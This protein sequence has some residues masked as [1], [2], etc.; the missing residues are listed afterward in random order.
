ME[1]VQKQDLK[2]VEICNRVHTLNLYWVFKDFTY[3]NLLIL[4]LF[5]SILFEIF[6]NNSLGTVDDNLYYVNITQYGHGHHCMALCYDQ[7]TNNC[8]VTDISNS[9]MWC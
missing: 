8:Q 1:N 3:C 7:I 5:V 6:H 2:H 9:L 4:Q